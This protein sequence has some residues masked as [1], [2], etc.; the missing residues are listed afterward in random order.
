MDEEITEFEKRLL[1]HPELVE[2]IERGI[3]SEIRYDREG[4]RLDEINLDE[5]P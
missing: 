2:Q 4:N 5:L 3:D 1:E